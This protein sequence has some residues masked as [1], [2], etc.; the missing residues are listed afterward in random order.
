MGRRV[1]LVEDNEL[2]REIATELLNEAGFKVECA[3]NGQIALD[4]V[5]GAEPGEF[6][7]ILMD[8]QMPVMNGYEATMRIRQLEN[9]ALAH[10]PVIA[11]TA[12]AFEEDKQQAAKAGMD[13]YLPKPI[14]IDKMFRLLR[15]TLQKS[16]RSRN[17]EVK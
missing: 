2:N 16:E 15:E 5:A 3:E 8:V 4:R 11:M 12:N 6:D 13:G 17:G 7:L 1:L 14:D 10:I 9:P